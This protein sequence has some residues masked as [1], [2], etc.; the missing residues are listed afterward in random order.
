MAAL[1]WWPFIKKTIQDGGSVT[2]DRVETIVVKSIVEPLPVGIQE[3]ESLVYA[4]SNGAAGG[5]QSLLLYSQQGLFVASKKLA[6][7]PRY[8]KKDQ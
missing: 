4:I 2:I 8:A 3:V 6:A 5:F 7:R 1:E